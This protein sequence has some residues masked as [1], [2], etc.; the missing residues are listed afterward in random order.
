MRLDKRGHRE[1]GTLVRR[2]DD[3]DGGAGGRVGEAVS[4]RAA[5]GPPPRIAG[6]VGS[7]VGLVV[8]GPPG[9]PGLRQRP[10]AALLPSLGSEAVVPP[11][12]NRKKAI[13]CDMEKYARQHLV[14]N[15]FCRI[16]EFRRIATRYDQTESSYA[17]MIRMAAVRLTLA[18]LSTC[19]TWLVM[20]S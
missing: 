15:F 13:D 17:V 10:F 11:K 5:G 14:E 3:E 20:V 1:I 16:R 8:G 7:A 6:S 18:Q 4:V 12:R 2:A 9:R 19:A